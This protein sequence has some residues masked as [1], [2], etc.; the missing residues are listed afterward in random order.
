MQIKNIDPLGRALEVPSLGLYAAHGETIE[1]TPE[2]GKALLTNPESW[3][4]VTATKTT[5][6]S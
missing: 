6:E 1:V 2:Q 5:K 4:A 3:Q